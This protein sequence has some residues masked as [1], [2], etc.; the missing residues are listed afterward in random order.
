MSVYSV[1]YLHIY[2]DYT[3]NPELRKIRPV[4][5]LWEQS[6]CVSGDVSVIKCRVGIMPQD[7]GKTCL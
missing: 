6:H 3:L 4:A 7:N 1:Q 2:F 5:N